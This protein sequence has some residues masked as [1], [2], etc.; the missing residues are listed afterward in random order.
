MKEYYAERHGLLTKEL[1]LNLDELLSYLWQTTQYFQH[2]GCFDLAF[3][4]AWQENRYGREQIK[5]PSMSP[6]PEVFFTVHLKN[7]NVWPFYEHFEYYDEITLFSVI[8]IL[9]DHIGVFN[10]SSGKVENDEL[11]KEYAEHINNLLKAYTAG[12]FLEPSKGFVMKM[13]NAALQEQLKYDGS[14]MPSSVFEQLQ[15]A[16]RMYYRFDSDLEMKKKA[17][18]ILADILENVR[19]DVQETFSQEYSIAKKEHD[20]LIFGIVNGFNIRHNRADQNDNYS[21][22]IWYDWMMQ[23]FTSVIIAY[24]KVKEVH[25]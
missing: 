24:Y 21:R 5:A 1:K 18:N 11:K 12:Y 15:S 17:I 10:Y 8:E 19:D 6:S 16:S 2:K 23:Y 20:K 22:E 25:F 13:P 9:Y 7:K 14:D 3:N 4:G